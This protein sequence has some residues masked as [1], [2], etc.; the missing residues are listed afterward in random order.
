M[1]VNWPAQPAMA[2]IDFDKLAELADDHVIELLTQVKGVGVWTV[3]MFLMFA[4]QRHDVLPVGDLGVRAAMKKAYALDELPKPADM[5]K[6][7]EALASLPVHCQLVSVAQ[8][9]K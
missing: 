9:R 3:Q 7:A 6:L 8:P 4:L 2:K 1:F 5:E